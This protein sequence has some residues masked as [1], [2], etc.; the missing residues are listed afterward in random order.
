MYERS[1]GINQ[2]FPNLLGRDPKYNHILSGDP[3]ILLFS[4]PHINVVKI[5]DLKALVSFYISYFHNLY[6]WNPPLQMIILG[7]TA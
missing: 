7:V 3:A 5:A 2:G 1:H 6:L 4:I